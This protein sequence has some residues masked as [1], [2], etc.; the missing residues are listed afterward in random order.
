MALLLKT[1][2]VCSLSNSNLE[3]IA[4]L[5]FQTI[6]L[7]RV[8]LI[9]VLLCLQLVTWLSKLSLFGVMV[10]ACLWELIEQFSL[11]LLFNTVDVT[12]FVEFSYELVNDLQAFIEFLA[13]FLV[14]SIFLTLSTVKLILIIRYL[15]PYGSHISLS[16]TELHHF[17]LQ[18]M[19]KLI[20]MTIWSHEIIHMSSAILKCIFVSGCH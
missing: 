7:S 1:V 3:G 14:V 10:S 6:K 12:E 15:L 18:F 16:S 4:D 5:I 8:D 9:S 13:A 17:L 19:Q 20:L 11:M 2:K